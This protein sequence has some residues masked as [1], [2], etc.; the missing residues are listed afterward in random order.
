MV[1]VV[2]A[3]VGMQIA[4]VACSS[5]GGLAVVASA[6]GIWVTRHRVIRGAALLEQLGRNVDRNISN[7]ACS[8]SG[9]KEQDE[10][11][12]ASGGRMCHG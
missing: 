10:C 7:M 1:K 6:T 9:S 3:A 4:K 2:E 11:K 8:H 5:A 12:W